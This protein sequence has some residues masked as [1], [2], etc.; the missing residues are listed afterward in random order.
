MGGWERGPASKQP[1]DLSCRRKGSQRKLGRNRVQS[2]AGSP[3]WKP[4]QVWPRVSLP[5][6][7]A[8]ESLSAERVGTHFL[9]YSRSLWPWGSQ[10]GVWRLL[11]PF[12]G[13][14]MVQTIFTIIL[15]PYFAFFTFILS[16]VSCGVFQRLMCDN[17]TTKYRSRHATPADFY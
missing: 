5:L 10:N 4:T 8:S 11:R 13:T 14:P 3:S 16:Q 1:S 17:I 2:S 6:L 9:W 12:Q 7:W 15:R